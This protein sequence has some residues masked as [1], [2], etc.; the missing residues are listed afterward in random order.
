[1][2]IKLKVF[3]KEGYML[4]LSNR[5]LFVTQVFTALKNLQ[6][7]LLII[8]CRGNRVLKNELKRAE[9]KYILAVVF[10]Q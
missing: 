8:L 9:S 10:F 3:T 1:M 2:K 7:T 5:L 4:D 6:L